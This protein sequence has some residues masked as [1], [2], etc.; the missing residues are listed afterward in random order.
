MGY[1]LREAWRGR[2]LVECRRWCDDGTGRVG[3]LVGRLLR[4]CFEVVGEVEGEVLLKLV[5]VVVP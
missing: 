3:L 2:G 1:N 4:L 5:W